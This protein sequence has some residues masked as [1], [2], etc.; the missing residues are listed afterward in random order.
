MCEV[1]RFEGTDY[2]QLKFPK[3]KLFMRNLYTVLKQETLSLVLC[4]VHEIE[5]FAI[6]E[7]RFM[8]IHPNLLRAISKKPQLFTKKNN[9]NNDDD[10]GSIA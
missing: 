7:P 2:R 8:E 5:L 10:S 3:T 6:G 9:N 1:C 4:Y